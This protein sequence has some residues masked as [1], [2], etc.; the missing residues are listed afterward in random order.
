MKLA[1]AAEYYE[2]SGLSKSPQR[3][4]RSPPACRTLFSGAHP[5][6]LVIYP[7]SSPC[8]FRNTL[9]DWPV[10]S[11]PYQAKHYPRTQ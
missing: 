3:N 2:F 10:V 9:M 6:A 5:R 1:D 7:T 4:D 11:T 8:M